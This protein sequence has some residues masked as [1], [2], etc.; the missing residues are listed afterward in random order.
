MDNVLALPNFYLRGFINYEVP[1]YRFLVGYV[2]AARSFALNAVLS[3]GPSRLDGPDLWSN[4]SWTCLL[5]ASFYL[6]AV[7]CASMAC[8]RTNPTATGW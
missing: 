1:F 7:V 8:K 2:S 3:V 5:Q 6:R 4:P